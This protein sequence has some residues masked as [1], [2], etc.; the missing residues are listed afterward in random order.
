MVLKRGG[1]GPNGSREFYSSVILNG[2]ETARRHT[3][4][5]WLFYSSVI[6]NGTETSVG[7]Q[8]HLIQ[9]Y[10]SV[11]LNGTETLLW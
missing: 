7:W 6:L 5:A 1:T 10:S 11:I 3:A 9:F 2:T 4:P 8:S